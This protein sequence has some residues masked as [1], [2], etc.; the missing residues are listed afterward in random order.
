LYENCKTCLPSTIFHLYRGGLFNGGGNWRSRR[1]PLTCRKSLI[2]SIISECRESQ[3][4]VSV[5]KIWILIVNNNNCG[6]NHYFVQLMFYFFSQWFQLNS[7]IIYVDM[8]NGV[9]YMLIWIMVLSI[10]WYGSWCC[11]CV[12]MDHGVVYVLIW[13]M[14]LSHIDNT[15]IHINIKT[16]TWSIS[17]HRQHHDPYQHIDNTMIHINT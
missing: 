10:C 15:M 7:A 12:D 11:L 4:S 16:T 2:N 14:V 17:T 13:I 1:K 8:D 3:N 6:R 9:V 5:K